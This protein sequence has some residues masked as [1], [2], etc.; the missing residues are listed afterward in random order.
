MLDPAESDKRVSFLFKILLFSFQERGRE[1]EGEGKRRQK[2]GCVRETSIGCLLHA[3]SWDLTHTPGMCP[4][5][6][7]N[8]QTFSLQDDAQL[9]EAHQWA[10]EFLQYYANTL[11]P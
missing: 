3:P 4:A 10:K 7:S 5:Q 11:T 8:Q 6:E 1:G 9:T 2:H